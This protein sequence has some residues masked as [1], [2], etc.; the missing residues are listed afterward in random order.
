MTKGGAQV[1][2]VLILTKPLG[3]GILTTAGKR[4]IA[5][6][7]V[8]DNA[9]RWMM[10]LNRAASDA[11][12]RVGVKTATDITGYSLLG[13]AYEMA[14][15]S[16]VQFELEWQHLPILEGALELAKQGSIP[17]GTSRNRDY[18]TG[19]VLLPEGLSEEQDALLFDPQTSGGLL[20]AIAADRYDALV[21]ALDERQVTH[22]NVGRVVEGQ[23][24]HVI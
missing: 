23:G 19:K 22:W 10:R 16:G 13:H 2:D 21:R 3:T 4:G 7:S 5:S 17:G 15:A 20:I 18:L 8:L 24:I 9:V 6:E 14:A 12:R 1:G 11:A